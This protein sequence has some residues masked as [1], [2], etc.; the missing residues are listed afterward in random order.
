MKWTS[1]AALCGWVAMLATLHQANAQPT[2]N[3]PTR[4]NIP[5]LLILQNK[6]QPAGDACSGSNGTIVV[7]YSDLWNARFWE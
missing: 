1:L 7:F 3:R 2:P 6:G 4:V 5:P